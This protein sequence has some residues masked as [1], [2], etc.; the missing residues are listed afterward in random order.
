[1][2][3][4]MVIVGIGGQGRECLDIAEAMSAAGAD[5]EVVG[6]VDD[7]PS[8]ENV[9]RVKARGYDLLG[10]FADAIAL[11]GVSI[12]LGIGNGEVRAKLDSV[13]MGEGVPSPVL[14]HPDASVGSLV[15]LSPGVVIFAGARLTTNIRVGR[16]VH[17]NQNA[18]IGHDSVLEDYVTVNPL[19]AVSGSV[20]VGTGAMLGASSVILQGRSVGDRAIIGAS[21][22]VVGDVPS[23]S[24][25]KGVP[26]R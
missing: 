14:V 23:Q 24:T 5:L 25:V 8:E 16:H 10:G 3:T 7:N 6:F 1:M 11:S 2:T 4:S 15:D 20:R 21:A 13:L 26:A 19:A 22:C 18:T 17:I 9:T 12:C